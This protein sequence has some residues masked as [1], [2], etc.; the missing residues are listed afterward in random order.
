MVR[1][2]GGSE[3]RKENGKAAGPWEVLVIGP[4][5]AFG[6][7]KRLALEIEKLIYKRHPEV[8]ANL[9]TWLGDCERNFG[10]GQAR[11]RPVYNAMKL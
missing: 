2:A 3:P 9:E 11:P 10:Q 6:D 1:K 8:Y 7:A 5:G 4:P